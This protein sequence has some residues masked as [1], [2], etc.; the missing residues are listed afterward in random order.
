[1]CHNYWNLFTRA[2]QQEKPLLREAWALQ[3]ESNP[4]SPREEP[5]QQRRPS[6]AKNKLIN[7]KMEENKINTVESSSFFFLEGSYLS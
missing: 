1:M 3:L 6:T 4:G 7:F 2:P 5:T